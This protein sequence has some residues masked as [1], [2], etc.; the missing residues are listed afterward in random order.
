VLSAGALNTPEILLRSETH[1]L[2]VAP[3]L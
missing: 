2:S 3:A 1:G